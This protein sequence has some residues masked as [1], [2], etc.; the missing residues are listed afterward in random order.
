MS[1]TLSDFKQLVDA[2]DYFKFFELTYD[3]QV[4]NVNRLHILQKFAQL[5]KEID[6]SWTGENSED[7]LSLYQEALQK[8]YTLFLTSTSLDEKLFKVFNQ[9]PANVVLLTEINTD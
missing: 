2:E 6:A 9:K 3:P 1:K 5:V 8:A 7:K 4:V